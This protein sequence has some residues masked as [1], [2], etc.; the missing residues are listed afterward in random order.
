[1][2]FNQALWSSVSY[3]YVNSNT[4]RHSILN[5]SAFT[6]NTGLSNNKIAEIKNPTAQ[7]FEFTIDFACSLVQRCDQ[8][9]VTKFEINLKLGVIQLPA[10][11]RK[12]SPRSPYIRKSFKIDE[13]TECIIDDRS[14]EV[15]K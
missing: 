10:V 13:Y 5:C 1:M 2:A 7:N 15:S 12:P 4:V 8:L 11:N 14:Q 6:R 3:A 9:G